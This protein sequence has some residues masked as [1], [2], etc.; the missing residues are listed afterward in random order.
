MANRKISDLTA[1]TTP[2]TGDLLP[3]VDISEAAAADKN[4]KITFGELFA[5]IPAGT[6]AAPS[7][8]FEGDSDTGIYSPGADQVAI[9]SNGT[10]RIVV[11]ASGNVNI[12]SNTFYVDAAN[13]R[14]GLGTS[15]P[16]TLLEVVSSTDDDH[17]TLYK[18]GVVGGAGAGIKFSNQNNVG[19][20]IHLA[21]IRNELTSGSP[22]AEGGA[23]VFT[24]KNNGDA[25]PQE[26]L[27]IDASG[28]LLVGTSSNSGGATIQAIGSVQASIALRFPANSRNGATTKPTAI[29]TISTDG[30]TNTA[31]VYAN[32]RYGSG[33][34]V[35]L[36]G[37]DSSGNAINSTTSTTVGATFVFC[38]TDAATN[39]PTT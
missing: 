8:A 18:T 2:A 35:F 9:S 5:S 3:I 33:K 39:F 13:N 32:N 23:L 24:T 36:A 25:S 30:G 1:L 29:E 22:G 37:F 10:S 19:T 20:R 15:S 26:R 38:I 27:C 28:R 6:A 7:V 17:L 31:T 12:D 34:W 11:D 4:K 21:G 16:G 14:V